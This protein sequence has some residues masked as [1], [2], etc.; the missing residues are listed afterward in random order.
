[1]RQSATSLPSNI[2]HEI[3]SLE[4]QMAAGTLLSESAAIAEAVQFAALT[5]APS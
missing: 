4:L 1:M 3:F 5:A 2:L